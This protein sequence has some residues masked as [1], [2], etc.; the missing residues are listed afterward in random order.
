LFDSSFKKLDGA[1]ILSN[2][3]L[4]FI[5]SWELKYKVIIVH[6]DIILTLVLEAFVNASSYWK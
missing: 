4:S 1:V 5:V 2:R 3:V 6:I